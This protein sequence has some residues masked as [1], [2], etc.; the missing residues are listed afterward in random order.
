MIYGLEI[1]HGENKRIHVLNSLKGRI[2]YC[3]HCGDMLIP[4]QGKI[5]PWHFKHKENP[6]CTVGEISGRGC[7]INT[8]DNNRYCGGSIE[9]EQECNLNQ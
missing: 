6:T 7:I 8:F 2:Y 4:H 9:C 3:E 1:M 5:M